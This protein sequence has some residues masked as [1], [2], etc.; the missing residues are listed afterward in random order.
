MNYEVRTPILQES[1]E[2]ARSVIIGV[3]DGSMEMTTATRVLSAARVFQSAVSTD[4]RA[5]LAAPR[6]A[7]QEA[8]QIEAEEQR[9]GALEKPRPTR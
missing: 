1:V 8:K 6:I 4:I 7:A 2:A 5:R 3:Q 9:T